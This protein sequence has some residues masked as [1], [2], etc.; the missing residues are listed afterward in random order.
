MTSF[1]S[2]P[3]TNQFSVNQLEQVSN[4]LRETTICTQDVLSRNSNFKT[5]KSRAAVEEAWGCGA[6]RSEQARWELLSHL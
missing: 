5:D 3:K 6:W 2:T 4:H 1:L